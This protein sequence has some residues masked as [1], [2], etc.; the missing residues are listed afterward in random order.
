MR[1]GMAGESQVLRWRTVRAALRSGSVDPKP[2]DGNV[3]PV[4]INS[5]TAAAIEVVLSTFCVIL[6]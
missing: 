1:R 6:L 5:F 2:A 3:I 4:G